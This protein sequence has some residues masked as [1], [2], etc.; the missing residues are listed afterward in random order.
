MSGGLDAL[1]ITV[2]VDNSFNL[3]Y[4]S[5]RFLGGSLINS[6]PL[7]PMCNINSLYL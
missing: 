5:A 6:F 2:S 1:A 7:E 3:C 4:F